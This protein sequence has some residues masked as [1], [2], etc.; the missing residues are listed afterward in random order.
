MLEKQL[1]GERFFPNWFR[2]LVIV[3]LSLRVA[4]E[5]VGAR[6]GSPILRL[7]I[8]SPGVSSRDGFLIPTR[9]TSNRPTCEEASYS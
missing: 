9:I 4:E 7:Q 2:F 6:N 3:I 8:L 5:L 1:G